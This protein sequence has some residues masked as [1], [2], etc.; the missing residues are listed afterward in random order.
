MPG[1]GETFVLQNE[2]EKAQV[3]AVRARD[4]LQRAGA[5]EEFG[6]RLAAL[7]AAISTTSQALQW[8][9]TAL[10]EIGAVSRCIE[11]AQVEIPIVWRYL[12]SC[13]DISPSCTLLDGGTPLIVCNLNVSCLRIPYLLL[14]CT[15]G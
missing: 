8:R 9:K 10:D 12:Q 1:T 14:F 2:I 3:Q 15:A 6:P 7:E 11:L 13:G 5:S 4:E